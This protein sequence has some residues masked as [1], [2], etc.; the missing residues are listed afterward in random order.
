MTVAHELPDWLHRWARL[1]P[2]RVALTAGTDDYS[3]AE[4]DQLVNRTARQL[5][6]AGV[7]K[8]SRVA[9]LLLNGVLYAALSYALARLGS[10]LV[11]LNVRLA[12]RE[13]AWQ[14]HDARATVLIYDASLGPAVAEAVAIISGLRRI[15]SDTL[16]TIP[17]ADVPLRYQVDLS[18]VQGVIYTSATTGKPKGA[19]ITYGNHWWNAIGS[20]LNLG[21]HRS[22]CWLALLPFYHI[23][24]MAILWRAA[25]FGHPIIV[26]G[27]FDPDAVN[28]EL[29]RGQATLCS[30]VSPMLTRMLDGRGGRPYPPSL[31]YML[32]GGGPIP[33][34]LLEACVRW[35]IP[36][37]PTY[38]LTETASQV[39]T[40]APQD[41]TQR[42]GSVGHPLFPVELRIEVDNRVAADGEVGEILVGGPTVMRGY[43]DRPQETARVLRNGWLHTGDLG[44]LDAEGYLYVVDRREDLIVSGGENVYPAEVE[45]VLLEHPAI[46]DA[47]VV[48][49]PDEVWGQAVGAAVHLRSN[50]GLIEDDVRTFCAARMAGFKV[51]RYVWFVDAIPRS[52]PGKIQRHL[53]RTQVTR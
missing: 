1:T 46:I 43:A 10:I 4:L 6:G 25:I 39:A 49:I 51:P 30:V 35:G 32:L 26:H 16:A 13:L 21:M 5:A 34:A 44:Y 36:V 28:R 7:T 31:R 15:D 38:G 23:G 8:G 29:D 3:F 37:A 52:G 2:S 20:G 48:G 19:E 17:E 40:L 41:V 14:L 45:A 9:I 42:I 12:E 27:V 24:G 18:D 22:D 53:L 11:P 33:R 50:A 47:A